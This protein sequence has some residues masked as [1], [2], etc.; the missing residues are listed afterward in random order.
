MTQDHPWNP[1]N[2]IISAVK[3]EAETSDMESSEVYR[4]IC[5][6]FTNSHDIHTSDLSAFDD[7]SIITRIVS[8]VKIAT[9]FCNQKSIAFVGAKDRHSRE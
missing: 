4:T 2:W 8:S 1:N 6:C 3:T 9:V 5:A 7:H